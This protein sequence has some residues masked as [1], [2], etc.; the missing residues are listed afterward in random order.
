MSSSP[1]PPHPTCKAMSYA[2]LAMLSEGLSESFSTAC[3]QRFHEQYEADSL[4]S[5]DIVMKTVT[6]DD[7]AS[8]E[9]RCWERRGRAPPGTHPTII[10][11]PGLR[12][13]VFPVSRLVVTLGLPEATCLIV[14]LP[15][16]GG[17]AVE[18]VER[19][20][21]EE[22]RARVRPMVARHT[23]AHCEAGAGRLAPFGAARNWPRLANTLGRRRH[24]LALAEAPGRLAEHRRTGRHAASPTKGFGMCVVRFEKMAHS[25]SRSA[26]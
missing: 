14:D 7:V 6:L 22:V 20:S 4:E 10:I 16:C 5:N 17:H 9:V 1:P 2:V 8:T 15:T 13:Q 21:A 18:P 23:R 11:L 25:P 24:N 26:R 12:E 3:A 19:D